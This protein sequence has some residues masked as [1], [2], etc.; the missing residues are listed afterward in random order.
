M[1]MSGVVCCEAEFI[2]GGPEYTYGVVALKRSK[3]LSL[4]GSIGEI[5]NTVR[6]VL[7]NQS[8]CQSV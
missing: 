3:K 1:L 7:I 8:I 5:W 2:C 6:S 4:A